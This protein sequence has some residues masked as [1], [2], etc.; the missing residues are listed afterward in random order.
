MKTRSKNSWKAGMTLVEIM[1]S[2]VI[3]AVLAIGG[4]SAAHMSRRTII[5]QRNRREALGIAHK[6]LEQL[7]AFRY[8]DLAPTT[9]DYTTYY[10]V[11]N[12]S[13]ALL[14]QTSDPDETVV[15]HGLDVPIETK[16]QYVDVD[17][18]AVPFAGLFLSVSVGYHEKAADRVELETFYANSGEFE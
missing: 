10:V 17:G 16:L 9:L 1:V 8:E 15:I 6:R 12:L 18:G 14:V 4:A 5:V 7:R 3:L 2:I 13:G 11:E